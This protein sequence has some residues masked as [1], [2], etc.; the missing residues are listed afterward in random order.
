MSVNTKNRK[1]KMFLLV[2]QGYKYPRLGSLN[3]RKLFSFIILKFFLFCIVFRCPA[4]CLN[5]H[6]LC[7]V[8]S[9]IFLVPQLSPYLVITI[10][11]TTFTMLYL[12]PCDYFVTTNLCFLISSL[13]HS[14]PYFLAPSSNQQ[15]TLCIYQSVLILFVSLFCSLDSMY[16]V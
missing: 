5:N 3:S 10:F 16:Y 15:F 1:E 2:F 4:K 9:L 14:P 12:Y 6:I 7:I 8:F 13:S 11:L